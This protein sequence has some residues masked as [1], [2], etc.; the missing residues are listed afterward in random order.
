MFIA[1]FGCQFFQK[2]PERLL[3]EWCYLIACFVVVKCEVC[4]VVLYVA[5]IDIRNNMYKQ[6]EYACHL[7]IF[8]ISLHF[9]S[10]C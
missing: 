10:L 7:I 4:I 8:C 3:Q 5:D 2:L 6:C 1:N 9:N